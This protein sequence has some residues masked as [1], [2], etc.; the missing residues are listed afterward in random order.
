[1]N[2]K[3][4]IGIDYSGAK[5]PVSCSSAHRNLNQIALSF[6]LN[7]VRSIKE[8]CLGVDTRMRSF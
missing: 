5:T 2:F 7:E 6:A 4:S 1:M 3:L 8:K